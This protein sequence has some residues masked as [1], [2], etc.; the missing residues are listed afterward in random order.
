MTYLQQVVTDVSTQDN[1]KR[2]YVCGSIKHAYDIY[3][4][5]DIQH[6]QLNVLLVLRFVTFAMV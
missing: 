4:N 3:P 1:Y 6:I 5:S 2:D